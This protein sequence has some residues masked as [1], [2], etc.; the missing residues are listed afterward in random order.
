M[1]ARV[2]RILGPGSGR[3]P[4]GAQTS[5]RWLR[6]LFAAGAIAGVPTAASAQSEGGA[7]QAPEVAQARID[8]GQFRRARELLLACVDSS[9]GGEV[10]PTCSTKLQEL[11]AVMPSL[12]FRAHD[13]EGNDLTNV[14]VRLNDEVLTS[15]LNGMALPVDPGSH[16]FT[17]E[18][19]GYLPVTRRLVVERGVQFTSIGVEI[20]QPLGAPAET[21]RSAVRPSP[22]SD[23]SMLGWTLTGVGLAAAGGFAWLGATGRERDNLLRESCHPV[24]APPDSTAMIPCSDEAVASMSTRYLMANVA[25]GLAAVSAGVGLVLLLTDSDSAEEA[26]AARLEAAVGPTGGQISLRGR[27]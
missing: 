18:R 22:T 7:C 2:V 20:S 23:R 16:D 25:A 15:R 8:A 24:T 12:V 21:A 13:G 5:A 4:S 3:V 26:G 1:A 10:R 9:C 6:S 14:V 27:F 11:N 19:S 17:F